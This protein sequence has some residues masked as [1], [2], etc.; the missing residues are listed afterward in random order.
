[1]STC[2]SPEIGDRSGGPLF[3]VREALSAGC[4][5]CEEPVYRGAL[6]GGGLHLVHG[7]PKG[8]G[9]CEALRVP[10]N[11]L[12]CDADADALAVKGVEILQVPAQHTVDLRHLRRRE[13]TSRR[14]VVLDLPKNPWSPLGCATDHHRISLRVCQD[15]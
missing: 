9:A 4:Q 12:A 1:M 13:V 11:V 7:L 14:E 8:R 3:L 5:S 15:S 6:T 10:R 2:R